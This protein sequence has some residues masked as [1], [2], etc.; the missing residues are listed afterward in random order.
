MDAINTINPR[1]PK[2]RRLPPS[3]RIYSRPAK[4]LVSATKWLPLI[5]VSSF[6]VILAKQN[7]T[8]LGVGVGCA[9]CAV[10]IRGTGELLQPGDIC[11]CS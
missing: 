11:F 1:L 10:K 5:V 7:T 8:L 4:M 3:L 2:W 6:A 9:H